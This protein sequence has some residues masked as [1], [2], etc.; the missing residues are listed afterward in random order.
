MS[1]IA[2]EVQKLNPSARIE[3]Y[4][5]D[6]SLAGGGIERIH[7]YVNDGDIVWQG[8]VYAPAAF[9][10]EGFAVSQDSQTRP[11]FTMANPNGAVSALCAAFDDFIGA[12]LTRRRTLARF[13]DAANFGGG[14]PDADPSQRFPDEVWY[15]ERKISETRNAVKFELTSAFDLSGRMLPRRQIQANKCT[16][17]V[18]G[19]YRGPYCGYVGGPVAKSDDT[20]T[21][22][23]AQDKCGGRVSSCKLRFGETAVL[24]YGG[25]PAAGMAR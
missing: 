6:A 17:L 16:W 5:L 22:D 3:L 4:E 10:A 21:A 9:E 12:K 13:L 24:P 20:A 23:P 14:N 18:I 25:F 11:T 2:K 7:N 1:E 8:Y 19:G 15:V